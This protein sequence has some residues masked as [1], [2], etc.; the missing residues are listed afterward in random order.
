MNHVNWAQDEFR[1]AHRPADGDRYFRDGILEEAR[2]IMRRRID[3][4]RADYPLDAAEEAELIASVGRDGDLEFRKGWP[5]LVTAGTDA[6][7]LPR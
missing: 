2:A 7:T 5:H 3:T 4:M 6:D 1:P